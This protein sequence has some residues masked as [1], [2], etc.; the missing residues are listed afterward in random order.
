PPDPDRQPT[1]SQRP[2]ATDFVWRR[3]PRRL[4]AD[5]DRRRRVRHHRAMRFIL[6][7]LA[8]S[9]S[10]CGADP[11]ALGITGAAVPAPPADPGES[12]TGIPN[13]PLTGTEYAPNLAPN[14]G[15][16]KFWGYN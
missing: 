6:L 12:Q 11:R 2:R 9:L 10:A 1:V 16:G 15:A 14:T 5:M 7:S 4:Q 3:S 13:A 8:L